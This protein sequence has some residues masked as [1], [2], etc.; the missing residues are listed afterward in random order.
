MGSAPQALALTSM[1]L[2]IFLHGI[3]KHLTHPRGHLTMS[4]I[5]KYLEDSIRKRESVSL[6]LTLSAWGYTRHLFGPQ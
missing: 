6:V 2:S 5:F 3:S 4:L 1:S